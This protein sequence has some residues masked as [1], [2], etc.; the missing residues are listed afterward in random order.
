[1]AYHMLRELAKLSNLKLND[2][3]EKADRSEAKCRDEE[4]R[5][6]ALW[7]CPV[8]FRARHADVL[9][10]VESGTGTWL[11]GHETFRSWV[12]GNVD[13]LWCPGIRAFPIAR[14]R[15]RS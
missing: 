1:M 8:S 15:R 11:L 9:E 14:T 12:K 13:A 2:L 5:K 7:I 3:N 10:S 6:I 4:A